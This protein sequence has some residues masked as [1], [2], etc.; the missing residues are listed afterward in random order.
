MRLELG[1][2]RF[3]LLAHGRGA[4][5][6]MLFERRNSAHVPER[7]E[8]RDGGRAH[9]SVVVVERGYERAQRRRVHALAQLQRGLDAHAKI[10]AIFELTDQLVERWFR[11]NGSRKKQK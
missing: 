9:R 1:E 6:P 7:L 5:E 10:L 8:R 3:D 11:Q 4:I 2:R